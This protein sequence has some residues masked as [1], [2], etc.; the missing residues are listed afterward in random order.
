MVSVVFVLVLSPTRSKNLVRKL[1]LVYRLGALRAAMSLSLAKKIATRVRTSPR[2]L[3]F[4][5]SCRP[6]LRMIA[7]TIRLKMVEETGLPWM[8]SHL[9]LKGQS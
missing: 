1:M 5:S 2:G 3:P 8:M 6:H 4:S 7:S 9:A